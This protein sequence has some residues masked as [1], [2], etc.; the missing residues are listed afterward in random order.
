M[1][2]RIVQELDGNNE[3]RWEVHIQQRVGFLFSKWTPVLTYF[4]GLGYGSVKTF[5][6]IEEARQYVKSVTKTQTI[7]EEGDV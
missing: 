1:K 7:I 4:P 3:C 6:S 5:K 2:Y